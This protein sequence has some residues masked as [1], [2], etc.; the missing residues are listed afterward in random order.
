M[1]VLAALSLATLPFVKVAPNRL[2]SGE[3]ASFLAVLQGPAWLLAVLIAMVFAASF[4]GIFESAAAKI[5][6]SKPLDF[7]KSPATFFASCPSS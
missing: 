2:M 4:T 3:P 6:F 1:S 7:R 5:Y